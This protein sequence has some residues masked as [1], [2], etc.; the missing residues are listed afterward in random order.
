M[1]KWKIVIHIGF[2]STF[3]FPQ[4]EDNNL[5]TTLIPKVLTEHPPPPQKKENNN[6][7]TAIN[8]DKPVKITDL[9]LS[10]NTEIYINYL[11]TET[12][13]NFMD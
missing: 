13:R 9:F 4:K 10:T 5:I 2:L 8:L 12:R 11:H 7:K 6:K 3:L 1:V